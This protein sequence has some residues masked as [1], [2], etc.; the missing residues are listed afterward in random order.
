MQT[1]ELL[2]D[3]TRHMAWADGQVWRAILDHIGE[4]PDAGLDPRIKSWLHHI[5]AVQRAFLGLWRQS[6]LTRTTPEDYPD[7]LAL[8]AW[9]RE[10]HQGICA[11]LEEAG[12]EDLD[13]VLTIPWARFYE[14]R[15]GRPAG[16]VDVRHSVVQVA[17]HT[18]H[19]RGQVTNRLREVGGEPPLIDY[20]AWMWFERPEPTWPE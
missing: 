20:I 12:E 18:A 17:M 15:Y 11:F 14:E 3:L 9:G 19:H 10:G 6:T 2:V 4:G 8:M 16:D 13:R 7:P 1:P 5:H